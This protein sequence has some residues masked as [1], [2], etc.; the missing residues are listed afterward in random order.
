MKI[1][2]EIS[3]RNFEFWSGAKDFA[4]SLTW[5]QLDT[6]EGILEGEYPEGMSDTEVN[7]LFWFEEDT[8]REWLNLPT[9]KQE[10]QNKQIEKWEEESPEFVEWVLGVYF[11]DDDRNDVNKW[12]D[13][14]DCLNDN[15]IQQ[16]FAD[17]QKDENKDDETEAK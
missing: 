13:I 12:E 14:L 4:N 7:D 15:D 11:W 8:I 1:Y 16:E 10:E 6:I 17:E 3:L 2:S 9:E 5:E